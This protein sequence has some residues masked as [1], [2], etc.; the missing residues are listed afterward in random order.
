MLR[1]EP[2]LEQRAED[3]WLHARPVEQRGVVHRAQLVGGARDHLGAVEEP[4]VEP[5]DAVVAEEAARLA[6]RHDAE[7]RG[8]P[9]VELLGIR[10]PRL[11]HAGEET[12]R[13]QP[14]VLGEEAEDD[15]VEVVGD[16]L[17]VVPALVHRPRDLGEA[18]RGELRNLV[19]RLLGPQRLGVKHDRAKDAERLG[20][21]FAALGEVVEGEFVDG[22]TG[23]G[24]VG[25]DLDAV[26]V[27]DDERGR[28]RQVLTVVEE[29]AV[30][31][32]EVGAV[33]L[34]LPAE[35]PALPDIGPAT[36]P[37]AEAFH[38]GLEGVVGA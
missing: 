30:G 21:A 29:L 3:G 1:V 11:D 17:R 38:T 25:V 18:R 4:A 36:A 35:V 12:R 5:L 13:E 22:G 19:G 10:A 23:A 34:V 16:G 33:P 8:E 9:A 24:E 20:G 32:G 14:G 37:C 27:A 2:A 28:V 6:V 26:H 7:Q 31:G 15:A